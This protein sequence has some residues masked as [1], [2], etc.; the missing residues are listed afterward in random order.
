MNG[1]YADRA[2]A[3]YVI[4]HQ[5]RNRSTKI[6]QAVKSLQAQRRWCITGTPVQ[7]RLEDLFALTEFLRFYPVDN[8]SNTRRYILSPLGRKEKH[9]LASLQSIMT[10]LALRRAKVACQGWGRSE[11]VEL[12]GLST[13]E[14]EKYHFLLSH[15]K[16]SRFTTARN[17]FAQVVLRTLIKL[18]QICS[19]GTLGLTSDTRNNVRIHG[20]N[21]SCAHCGDLVDPQAVVDAV[22][23]MWRP[24]LCYDCSLTWMY[25]N[26]SSSIQHSSSDEWICPAKDLSIIEKTADIGVELSDHSYRITVDRDESEVNAIEKSSKLKRILSN[27]THLHQTFH[28]DQF[29]VKRYLSRL[30]S[31]F[32]EKRLT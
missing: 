2:W 18:R 6:F 27:L 26:P 32:Y 13:E 25:N 11:R 24:R 28:G 3:C 19:H 10:I 31:M 1:H 22:P 21:S 4:A 5:I 15:T 8:Y 16:E 14:R 29:P 20:E 12:V 7:N 30:W 23:L 17:A 9:G